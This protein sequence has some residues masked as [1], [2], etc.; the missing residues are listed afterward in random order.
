MESIA[1]QVV[2]GRGGKH[3]LVLMAERIAGGSKDV[4]RPENQQE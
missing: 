3:G 4:E 2:D 1:A